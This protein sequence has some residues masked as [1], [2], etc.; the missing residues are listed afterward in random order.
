MDHTS[1]F[2]LVD[3]RGRLRLHEAHDLPADELVE[4]VRRLLAEEV[5]PPVR[6]EAPVA[7]LTP[8][9]LGAIYLRV[10][11]PSGDE[12]RLLSAESRAAERTEVHESVRSGDVVRMVSPERGFAVPPHG[13]LELAR[14]GKHLM[15]LGLSHRDPSKPIP[16]TLHFE[17]SGPIAVDVPVEGGS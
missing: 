7:Y 10:V 12:D 9:G 13:A 14:G 15:L 17:R 4:D 16:L 1:G 5:P 8:S 11:N 6:V 2:F 3:K